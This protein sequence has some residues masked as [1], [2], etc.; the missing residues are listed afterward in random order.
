MNKAAIIEVLSAAQADLAVA[1]KSGNMG[2]MHQAIARVRGLVASVVDTLA[3]SG[4]R[5]GGFAAMAERDP[6]RFLKIA[7]EADRKGARVRWGKGQ[8]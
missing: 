8:V 2:E 6:E 7:Q 4:R 1:Q 3:Q 5:Y